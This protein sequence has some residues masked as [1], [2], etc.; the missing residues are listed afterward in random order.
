MTLAMDAAKLGLW[1]WNVS[2]DQLWGS[3]ARRALLGLPSSGTIKLE[4]GLARV[5]AD[6]RDRVRRTLKDAA[7]TGEDYHLEYRVVL[8]DGTLQWTDHRGRCV[9]GAAGKDLILRGISMDVTQRK[10]AEEEFRMAV[11]ASPSGILLVNQTGQI[12][13]VNSQ[14]EKLFG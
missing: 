7:R 4:Q 12:V 9:K 3:K 14:I 13:L 2:K 1:E 11:E 10:R 6:D 5:H 8:P